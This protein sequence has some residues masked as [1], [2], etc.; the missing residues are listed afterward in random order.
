[1]E[2]QASQLAQTVCDSIEL[3]GGEIVTKRSLFLIPISFLLIIAVMVAYLA[4]IQ[5]Q[6]D[7]TNI[8]HTHTIHWECQDI[9]KQAEVAGVV[10][11]W[12]PNKD[13]CIQHI[14]VWLGNPYDIMWEGDCIITRNMEGSDKL[15]YHYQ[16]DSHTKSGIPHQRGIDLRPGILIGARE[17]VYIFRLFNNCSDSQIFAGDGWVTFYYEEQY[18]SFMYTIYRYYSISVYN[19]FL[20]DEFG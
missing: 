4:P 3:K 2:D 17:I 6:A 16:F 19:L 5:L 7:V 11:Q 20:H 1:M 10:G 15:I 13:V 14:E 8:L 9:N 12:V 18:V